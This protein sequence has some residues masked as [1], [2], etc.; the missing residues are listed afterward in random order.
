MEYDQVSGM[1]MAA[2]ILTAALLGVSVWAVAHY[3]GVPVGLG[4]LMYL[5]HQ[6]KKF[7][8][9]ENQGK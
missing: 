6:P 4:V 3:F 9:D 1:D 2:N 8:R 5:L 7:K